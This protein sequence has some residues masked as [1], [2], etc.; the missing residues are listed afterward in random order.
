M[1]L[2]RIFFYLTILV[3]F[4]ACGEN[5][6]SSNNSLVASESLTVESEVYAGEDKWVMVNN[7]LILEGKEILHE[8]NVSGYLWEY[9]KNT[10]ANT[11]KFTYRPTVI[12]V[13]TLTFSILYANGV[14]R[15]DSLNIVVTD[16]K[17]NR[18]IVFLE[19]TE[20]RTY[21]SAINKT[22]IRSQDCGLEGV[23]LA[24]TPVVWSEK[25]YSAAYEHSQDLIISKTFSHDGSGTESD[26]SGYKLGKQSNLIDRSEAYGYKWS[27]LGENLAGGTSMNIAEEAINSWLKSDKHCA[28]LMNPNF[29]EVGMAMLKNEDSVYTYYWSQN[30]GRSK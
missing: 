22:R 25:L 26:W 14:K 9:E 6:K 2:L 30:F 21:L 16:R 5:T 28:N 18:N 15:S 29:Q 17:V 12:G 4:N 24:T 10:L 8:D 27:T 23:F 3:V 13:H 7:A 1:S 11:R 19:E 20:K